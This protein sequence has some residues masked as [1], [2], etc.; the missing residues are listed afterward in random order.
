MAGP[1]FSAPTQI[2]DRWDGGLR[3][4]AGYLITP[5]TLVFGTGGVA[6]MQSK[7]SVTC[8]SNFLTSWCSGNNQATGRTDSATKTLPG[9]TVGAGLE[10]IIMPNWFLRGEYRYTNYRSYHATLLPNGSIF[11]LNL[12]QI[13]ANIKPS[14]QTALLGIAYHFG[15]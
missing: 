6:W 9:W 14:T 7:A 12:D 13:D 8:D 3:A 1:P 15:R 10:T 11:G 4:R 5:T 2:T